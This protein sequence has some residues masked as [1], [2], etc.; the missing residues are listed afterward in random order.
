[1]GIPNIVS[2][3]E[4]NLKNS[5]YKPKIDGSTSSFLINV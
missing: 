4:D 1:M 5:S 3:F 2:L